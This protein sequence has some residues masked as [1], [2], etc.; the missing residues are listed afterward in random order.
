MDS[1]KHNRIIEEEKIKY[2][3]QTFSGYKKTQVMSELK[4]CIMKQELDRAC[5]WAVE[6]DIS[7]HSA[8]LWENLLIFACDEIN[9]I[10]PLLPVYLY[11]KYM[12]YYRLL[13]IY[14]DNEIELRNNQEARNKL[15]DLICVITLSPKKKF[16]KYK[17]IK[18]IDLLKDS[19]RKNTT[20]KN[21]DLIKKFITPNDPITVKVAINEI[22]ICLNSKSKG[23]HIVEKCFYWIDWLFYYEKLQLKK[24]KVFYCNSRPRLLNN[25][26]FNNDCVWLLWDIINYFSK[27]TRD[28][29]LDLIIKS[30]FELY[31]IDFNKGKKNK[32]IVYIKYAVMLIMNCIPKINFNT[33][34]FYKNDIRFKANLNI[35]QVYSNLDYNKKHMSQEELENY[36]NLNIDIKIKKSPFFSKSK[37]DDLTNPELNI[38]FQKYMKNKHFGLER[39]KKKI[40]SKNFNNKL[41]KINKYKYKIKLNNKKIKKK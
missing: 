10:N 8:K 35:N 32:R 29:K 20:A 18:K 41:S 31:K 16:P 21:L 14:K 25:D 15:C 7:G 27:I 38:K 3:K 22:A 2:T 39:T 28:D 5:M 23:T 11:K 34:I 40:L 13:K 33:P 37:Y 36:R 24:Y 12:E 26:K 9:I 19:I 6:L 30:L 4:K 17:K 1:Y